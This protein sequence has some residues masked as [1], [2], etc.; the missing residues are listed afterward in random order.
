MSLNCKVDCWD[1]LRLKK[2]KVKT[3]FILFFCMMERKQLVF[4]FGQQ[5]VERRREVLLPP[6]QKKY[7][8]KMPKSTKNK[9]PWPL[10]QHTRMEGKRIVQ[11]SMVSHFL[12]LSRL[13]IL[14][15]RGYHARRSQKD[16]N[17]GAYLF[18]PLHG[19][20]RWLVQ[21]WVCFPS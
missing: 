3:E 10:K 9:F 2:K 19:I 13:N 14:F 6:S 18:I 21:G 8:K 15:L 5:R 16:D 1:H 20:P 11:H 17:H 12:G 4:N 7:A